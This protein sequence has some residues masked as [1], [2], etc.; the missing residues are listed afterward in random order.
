[1]TF[2]VVIL[3]LAVFFGAYIA[4]ARFAPDFLD[5]ILYTREELQILNYRP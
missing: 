4:V 1:M 2:L 5:Q 3:V